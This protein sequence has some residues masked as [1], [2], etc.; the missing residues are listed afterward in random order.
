MTMC[1]WAAANRNT[2]DEE[3]GTGFAINCTAWVLALVWVISNLTSGSGATPSASDARVSG[4][5]V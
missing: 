2:V 1:L 3:Y 4:V 5:C